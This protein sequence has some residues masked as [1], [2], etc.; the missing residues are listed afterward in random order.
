MFIYIYICIYIYM[1]CS[2]PSLRKETRFTKHVFV[3]FAKQ[4]FQNG[5]QIPKHWLQIVFRNKCLTVIKQNVGILY[6][7]ELFHINFSHKNIEKKNKFHWNHFSIP[8]A[9]TCWCWTQRM[10]EW[11]IAMELSSRSPIPYVQ[12]QQV[13]HCTSTSCAWICCLGA[14]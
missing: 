8:A 5:L 11:S 12:H 6:L 10:G 3:W 2:V 4:T 9:F 1:Y 13:S 14:P 7:V